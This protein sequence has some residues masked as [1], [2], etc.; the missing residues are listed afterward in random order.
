MLWMT[1]PLLRHLVTNDKSTN[2]SNTLCWRLEALTYSSH[3][4]IE[5]PLYFFLYPK[6][7][8]K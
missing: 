4:I 1:R 6:A 5:Q 2:R 8:R 3:A 7:K